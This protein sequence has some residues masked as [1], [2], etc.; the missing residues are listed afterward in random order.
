MTHETK[1]LI[2]TSTKKYG[3]LFALSSHAVVGDK[4]AMFMYDEN[5][6]ETLK[7]FCL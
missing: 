2:K 5:C 4:G 6:I 3:Y 7:L 1:K